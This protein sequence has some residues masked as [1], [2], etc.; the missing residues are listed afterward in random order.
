MYFY[1]FSGSGFNDTL[2]G[3]DASLDYCKRNNRILLIDGVNSTYKINYSDY[4]DFSVDFKFI[5][6]DT[7]QIKE[8][9]EKHK[10]SSVYP[11]ILKNE[12]NDLINGKLQMPYHCNLK[13]RFRGYTYKNHNFT[14]PVD[15]ITE[16]II[17]YKHIGGGDGYPIFKSLKFN[18]I[19]KTNCVLNYK[20]VKQPYLA[21][22]V[23]NTDYKCEYEKLYEDNKTLIH[24]YNSIYLATD[25]KNS[26]LFF[27]SKGLNLFNFATLNNGSSN[28]INLHYDKS[29]D[30]HIKFV[31]LITDIFLCAMSDKL[32]SNSKGGFIKLIRNCHYDKKHIKQMFDLHI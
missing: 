32:Q 27:L 28:F 9:L 10:D 4:F 11:S 5:I 19:V 1:F 20:L 18:N 12:M 15:D 7:M 17:V 23:R 6:N 30:P 13:E 16:T 14:F 22:Q 29:I 2:C 24:S 21:I 3:I 8:I 26:I 25:D 31:D